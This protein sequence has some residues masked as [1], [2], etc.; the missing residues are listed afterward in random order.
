[1]LVCGYVQTVTLMHTV[2][3]G[4]TVDFSEAGDHLVVLYSQHIRSNAGHAFCLEDSALWVCSPLGLTG[5]LVAYHLSPFTWYIVNFCH[6]FDSISLPVVFV[7]CC[8]QSFFLFV[9][10]YVKVMPSLHVI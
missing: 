3:T 1:M 2:T 10:N 6:S 5:L 8:N 9:S 7:C 4:L